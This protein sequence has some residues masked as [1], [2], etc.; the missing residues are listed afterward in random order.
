MGMACGSTHIIT[1]ETLSP[2][3][4][5]RVVEQYKVTLLDAQAH[6]VL[7]LFKSEAL[8]KTNLSSVKYLLVGSSKIPFHVMHD[9][10]LLL[11]NGAVI[12]EYGLTEVGDISI[13]FP[14]FSGKDD[15]GRLIDDLTVKIVDEN[16]N[17]C[18]VGVD[19]EICVKTRYDFPGYY[20]NQRLTDIAV[21]NEG[22]FKTGDIGHIDVDGYVYIVSRKKEVISQENE[23]I[24]PSE[25]EE[26]LLK[27]SDI[28]NVYVVGVPIDEVL[29]L[30]AAVV[31]RAKQS[32]ITEEDIAKL[33][34]GIFV[35][36]KFQI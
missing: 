9:F 26:V 32:K 34:T 20:K 2:E 8:H 11:P 31:E 18:G 16:D 30:P 13:G 33:V 7:Q 36:F 23:W 3:S 17:R 15:V 1:S 28:K 12:I 10:D 35:G 25:I 4:K 19:G 22:F 24:Y 21:D 27:S 29:E 6:T 14:K 5:L